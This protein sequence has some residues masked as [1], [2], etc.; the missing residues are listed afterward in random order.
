MTYAQ[1]GL[2]QATDYNNLTGGPT[3]TTANTLNATWVT[4]S[5]NA[6]YGQTALANVAVGD[7]HSYQ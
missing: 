6:G 5:G 2:V 3:S 7:Q 1:F 4:G